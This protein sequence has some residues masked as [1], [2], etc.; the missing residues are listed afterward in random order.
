MIFICLKES[1]ENGRMNP[2]STVLSKL[3]HSV[4]FKMALVQ[5]ILVHLNHLYDF[6]NYMFYC[7]NKLFVFVLFCLA[8]RLFFYYHQTINF[9]VFFWRIYEVM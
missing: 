5:P 8:E 7:E 9:F 3:R 1:Y 6:K 4:I 2:L